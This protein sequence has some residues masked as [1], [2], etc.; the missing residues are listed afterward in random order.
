MELCLITMLGYNW[1]SEHKHTN[2]LAEHPLH[3]DHVARARTFTLTEKCGSRLKCRKLHTYHINVL[4][5]YKHAAV[6]QVVLSGCL[7]CGPVAAA[8]E[9]R[10]LRKCQPYVYA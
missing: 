2:Q 3:T 5:L 1:N 4:H 8:V 6:V 9:L 10:H 7:L